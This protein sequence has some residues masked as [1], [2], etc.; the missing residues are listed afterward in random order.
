MSL[1]LESLNARHLPAPSRLINKDT[2]ESQLSPAFLPLPVH[3]SQ[4]PGNEPSPSGKG[5]GLFID[6]IG[7]VLAT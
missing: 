7:Q 5:S 4:L 6:T 3:G 2:D 1:Q